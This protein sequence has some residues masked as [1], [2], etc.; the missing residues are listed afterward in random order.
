MPEIYCTKVNDVQPFVLK[1]LMVPSDIS[2][3]MRSQII[4]K[5]AED[6]SANLE[7]TPIRASNKYLYIYIGITL[8]LMLFAY[9]GNFAFA[10]FTLSIAKKLHNNML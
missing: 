6:R 5:C 1:L 9:F 8:G 4:A 3:S 10:S 7:T 2:I